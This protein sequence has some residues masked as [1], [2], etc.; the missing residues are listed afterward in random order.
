VVAVAGCS[1]PIAPLNVTVKGVPSDVLFGD[2]VKAVVK[3]PLPPGGLTPPLGPPLP[4]G[5]YGPPTVTPELPLP[6]VAPTP[7]G[8]C[9]DDDPLQT[10][11]LE[12]PDS[13]L[14]PPVEG[15]YPYRVTGMRVD[16]KPISG[17]ET[18][19]V[20]SITTVPDP[21]GKSAAANIEFTVTS[22]FEGHI[23]VARYRA[24]PY[25]G[26]DPVNF[27]PVQP[28]APAQ[29]PSP[30]PSVTPSTLPVYSAG[31]PAVPGLYLLSLQQEGEVSVYNGDA[32]LLMV[33]Y[34]VVPGASFSS[35][36]SD[37]TYTLSYTSTVGDNAH[38]NACGVPLDSWTVKIVGSAVQASTTDGPTVEVDDRY[39]FGPQFGTIPLADRTKHVVTGATSTVSQVVEATINVVP[40]VAT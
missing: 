5:G 17:T 37:G 12:A 40:K 29:P 7:A 27:P 4:G 11:E 33:Q 2:Q 23:A 30:A 34:P 1:G 21:S 31:G 15:S 25:N 28:T 38:V 16:G 19:S 6:S 3:V 14:V 9:P 36:A 18:R 26:V 13:S 35:S 20:G 24:V 8:P 32:G 22:T 10:P 39:Q